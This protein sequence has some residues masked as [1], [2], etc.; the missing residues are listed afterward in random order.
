MALNPGEVLNQRY[1]IE[2]LLGKG[3]FGA[4]YRAWDLNFDLPC[5]VKENIETSPEAQRQFLREARLLH[6][7][8]HPN[9]PLVKD[10]FILPGQGQYLIMDYIEGQDLQEKLDQAGGPLPEAQVLTWLGEICAAL[11]YLHEHQPPI[12]HRDLKPANIRVT[13]QGQAV[14]V[15][16]GISKVY[17]P[18]LRTTQGARA[19]T[20]GYSP[21]E[22]YGQASTDARTDIYA[23]GATAYALLTGTAPVEAIRRISGETLTPPRRLNPQISPHVEQAILRAME[24]LPANRFQS[25]REFQQA[26]HRDASA[27]EPARVAPTLVSQPAYRPASNFPPRRVIPP[28]SAPAAAP[29]SAA[30]RSGSPSAAS[31]L[32]PLLIGGALGLA[33]IVVLA[34]VGG[35]LLLAGDPQ[36]LQR[37]GLAAAPS[38]TPVPTASLTPVPGFTPTVVPSDTPTVVPS[39]TPTDAPTF[40]PLPSPTLVGSIAGRWEGTLW[41][42]IGT[43][44]RRFTLTLDIFQQPGSRVIDGL[45]RLVHEGDGM[46]EEYKF[47]GTFDGQIAQFNE[48][49]GRHFWAVLKGRSLVGNVSWGC[50]NCSPWGEFE[51]ILK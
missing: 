39:Y 49:E 16:F 34:L 20:P 38:D 36:A 18:T 13:P 5:A 25:V 19:V 3:G 1:R 33:V 40:T 41:E 51:V 50:Y 35:A 29:R 45:I 23:L 21:V 27:G 7:L 42:K 48:P 8:R 44:P 24:T 15:D 22:Q 32:K 4:V 9:L 17:D 26:L 37:F 11:N 6:T 2:A 30:P 10:H 14:L 12:I 46:V 28:P 47:T 43:S 31:P